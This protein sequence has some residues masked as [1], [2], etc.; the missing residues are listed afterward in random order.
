MASRNQLF[1]GSFVHSKSLDELE[2]LH[3]TAVCVD[4]TGTII[5]VEKGCG[6]ATAREGLLQRLGWDEGEVEIVRAKEGQFFFPG[7]IG[8]SA[9]PIARTPTI[10]C[11]RSND[12]SF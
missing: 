8:E 12:G 11:Q 6:E 1:L 9:A 7:F 4:K 3:D 2:C 5:A 10:S